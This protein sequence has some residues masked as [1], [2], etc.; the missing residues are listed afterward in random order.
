MTWEFIEKEIQTSLAEKKKLQ[1]LCIVLS[2]FEKKTAHAC[3]CVLGIIP[4][5]VM[6]AISK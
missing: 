6:V 5:D 4:W 1:N 3:M 2:Y